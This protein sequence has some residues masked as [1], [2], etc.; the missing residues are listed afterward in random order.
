VAPEIVAGCSCGDDPQSQNAYCAMRVRI[1]KT[2]AA[3]A[4]AVIDD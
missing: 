1:D 3:A 4:F 2:T